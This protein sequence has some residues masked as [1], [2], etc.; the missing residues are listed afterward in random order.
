M[1]NR[2]P[3]FTVGFD[4]DLTLVDSGQRIVSS[5][6]QAFA[7]LGVQVTADDLKPLLGLP[8]EVTG[9]RIDPEVDS[10]E[11]V[12]AYRHH[13]DK[14]S[15]P[16]HVAMPGARAALEAVHAAGGRS[17]VVSAKFGPAVQNALREAGLAELVDFIH[18][19]RFEEGKTEALSQ[20]GAQIYVGDHVADMVSAAA[21]PCLGVGVTTGA[22]TGEQLVEAGATV[23]IAG[24]AE[25]G[26][27][28]AATRPH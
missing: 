16:P 11:L 2:A 27:W 20:E 5:Y 10:A 17:V 23:V 18:A 25:F 3:T 28:L 13:Y 19:E 1:T 8:I 7:D 22:F 15:A 12:A 24:M 14:P 9:R 21:V 26:P 6:Q 4:L